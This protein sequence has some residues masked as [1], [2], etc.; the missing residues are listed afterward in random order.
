MCYFRAQ[1]GQFVLNKIF[2]VQTIF[3]TFVYLLVLFIVQNLQKILT[4]D[5]EL[6]GCIIFGAKMVHL[7]QFFLKIINKIL[8]YL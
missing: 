3:I 2:F 8:I 4:A 7:P 6:W 5:P 1:N